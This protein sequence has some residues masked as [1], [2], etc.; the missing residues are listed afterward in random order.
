M[1]EH[2]YVIRG[3]HGS[4]PRGGA[5]LGKIPR[6]AVQMICLDGFFLCLSLTY[7]SV[8][9]NALENLFNQ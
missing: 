8:V 4:S 1:Y 5:K 6:Q 3:V 2:H 7:K 9:T